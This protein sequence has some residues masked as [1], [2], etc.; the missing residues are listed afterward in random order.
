MSLASLRYPAGLV[1]SFRKILWS[2]GHDRQVDIR[3]YTA[4]RLQVKAPSQPATRLL[5][6]IWIALADDSKAYDALYCQAY[7]LGE[8]C[9]T[10]CRI[11]PGSGQKVNVGF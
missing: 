5:C 1:N 4:I 11:S 9:S 7:F 8:G 2:A 10:N 3:P 6:R